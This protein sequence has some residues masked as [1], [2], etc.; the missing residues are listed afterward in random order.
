MA[1]EADFLVVS[2]S[3]FFFL[4]GHILD[5]H[6]KEGTKTILMVLRGLL[7]ILETV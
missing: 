4:N 6:R 5:S 7:E 2:G 1:V 3:F